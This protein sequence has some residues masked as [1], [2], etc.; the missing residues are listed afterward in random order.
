MIEQSV[1]PYYTDALRMAKG[2]KVLDIDGAAMAHF[3][4][5]DEAQAQ[6]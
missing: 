1:F 5:V 6:Y 4:N 3:D 2:V